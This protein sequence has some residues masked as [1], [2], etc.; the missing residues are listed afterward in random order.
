MWVQAPWWLQAA[1]AGGGGNTAG[2]SLRSGWTPGRLDEAR[3][4]KASATPSFIGASH[5]VLSHCQA[6]PALPTPCMLLLPMA[7]TRMV[8]C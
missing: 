7:I 6:L 2:G 5:T 3:E 1:G 4:G 8:F